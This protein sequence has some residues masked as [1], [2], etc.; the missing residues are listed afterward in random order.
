LRWAGRVALILIFTIACVFGFGITRS[1]WEKAVAFDR[2]AV[3]WQRN[4]D[5]RAVTFEYVDLGS[6]AMQTRIAGVRVKTAI[7]WFRRIPG[8]PES[9][10]VNPTSQSHYEDF[11]AG[12]WRAY[13]HLSAEQD[14]PMGI[15]ILEKL[16]T[17]AS[18]EQIRKMLSSF[19]L[20]VPTVA[21]LGAVLSV[22][23]LLDDVDPDRP[24]VIRDRPFGQEKLHAADGYSN[25]QQ[26]AL[27]RALDKEL[28]QRDPERWRT[29]QVSD[30]LS[31]I[32]AQG[33]GMMYADAIRVVRVARIAGRVIVVLFV[34][35][36][37]AR[38]ALASTR[39]PSRDG[40]RVDA[41]AK[42]EDQHD[43]TA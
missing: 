33:Y 4:P 37:I 18:D 32:W 6:R 13:F 5:F 9:I 2:A 38:L 40:P 22:R 29:K 20:P 41:G 3:R 17:H 7:M 35:L 27:L 10:A 23:S 31:G 24:F 14:V 30:F 39:G 28:R 21:D 43:T 1:D 16:G 19:R 15:G 36:T 34:A 11:A 12:P 25:E 26:L 8:L 42:P